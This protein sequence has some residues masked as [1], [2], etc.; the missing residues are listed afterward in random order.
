MMCKLDHINSIIPIKGFQSAAVTY[1]TRQPYRGNI[2]MIKLALDIELL[3]LTEER[4]DEYNEFA[5]RAILLA[6]SGNAQLGQFVTNE[7]NHFFN[8]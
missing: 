2:K 4:F 1:S 8:A 5:S 7:W 6:D 3:L